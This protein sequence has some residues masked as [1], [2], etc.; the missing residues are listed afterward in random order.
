[1]EN[2]IRNI[3]VISFPRTSSKSLVKAY[4]EKLQKLPAYGVLHKP[5]YLGKN[6]Y[7]VK[8]VVFSFKHVLHGHWHSLHLLD[9]DV[10]TC[11]KQN[12]K[13]VTC[14]RDIDKVRS[15]IENITGRTDLFDDLIYKS[16]LEKDK[17]EVWKQHVIEGDNLYT[18]DEPPPN[19]IL[20]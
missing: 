20:G 6:D 10:I 16:K 11:L 14:Y 17:W 9:E 18:V 4:S 13:I 2:T 15:S 19:Y 12:Y 8:E 7:N 5:E 3:A 1:M